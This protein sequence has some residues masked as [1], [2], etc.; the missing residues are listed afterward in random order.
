M[1]Q[2]GLSDRS[3]RKVD[4]QGSERRIEASSRQA[5]S[6]AS[7]GRKRW[8]LHRAISERPRIILLRSY[9]AS[10]ARSKRPHARNNRDQ[11]S[12]CCVA[13]CSLIAPRTEEPSPRRGTFCPG[14]RPIRQVALTSGAFDGGARRWDREKARPGSA[15]RRKA[16][17]GRKQDAEGHGDDHGAESPHPSQR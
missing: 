9:R 1:F 15:S 16:V 3:W 6:G 12:T 4:P 11:R 7:P 2:A 17:K 14:E 5:S 10:G 13:Y 8:N